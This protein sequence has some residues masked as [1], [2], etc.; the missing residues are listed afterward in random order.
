MK[1]HFVHF[2]FIG[3]LALSAGCKKKTDIDFRPETSNAVTNNSKGSLGAFFKNAALKPEVFQVNATTGGKFTSS[4]GITYTIDPGIFVKP[5]G[6]TAE[7]IVDVAVS[8]I[9]KPSEMIMND[10]PTNAIIT[11]QDSARQ[12]SINNP[13]IQEKGGMLNS[14]GEIKVEAKQNNEQLELKADAEVKVQIPQTA[15]PEPIVPTELVKTWTTRPVPTAGQIG[16]DFNNQVVFGATTMYESCFIWLE[17]PKPCIYLVNESNVPCLYM[18]V[19][20]LN[21]YFNSDVLVEAPRQT[22]VLGYFTNVF[23]ESETIENLDGKQSNMLFFKKKGD[24][25]VYK[26][27][28]NILNAPEGKKGLLS[29]QNTMGIGM[30]GTFIA[31]VNKDGKF[32]AEKKDA[33]IGEPAAGK[34]FVGINFTLN[35]VTESQMLDLIKSVDYE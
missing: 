26:L 4:K 24:N 29:Y 32:Y 20:R 7:G 28:N 19:P 5:N 8:E 30:E 12:D 18:E 3:I 35:E 2:A 13:K 33:T 34:N 21:V 6:Q 23:N 1:N 15:V 14:F 25:A 16:H 11:P 9:T 27:Y 10:M 31:L 17:M 22:T